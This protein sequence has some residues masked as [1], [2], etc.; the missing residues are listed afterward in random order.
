[1]PTPPWHSTAGKTSCPSPSPA[2]P[3]PQ[4]YC[5]PGSWSHPSVH[6]T[7]IQTPQASFLLWGSPLSQP[8]VRRHLLQSETLLGENISRTS[9]PFPPLALPGCLQLSHAAAQ[10]LHALR[11]GIS[12]RCC[13][14][15][16][17]PEGS[18]RAGGRSVPAGPHGAGTAER[19]G[20][21]QHRPE[22]S[23]VRSRAWLPLSPGDEWGISAPQYS[24]C[25][26]G[27]CHT[28]GYSSHTEPGGWC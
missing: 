14:I 22:C 20:A 27:Q 18:P 4:L 23:A 24:I 5:A 19:S 2:S 26:R 11:T 17:L 13:G 10:P 7:P 8:S 21:A 1:M 3:S 12:P 25:F 15:P 16:R 6:Q 28:E 9:P